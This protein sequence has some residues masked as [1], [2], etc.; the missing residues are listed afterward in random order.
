LVPCSSPVGYVFTGLLDPGLE[1]LSHCPISLLYSKYCDFGML[2]GGSC[3]VQRTR[4][5]RAMANRIQPHL[6]SLLMVAISSGGIVAPGHDRHL[7]SE[8]TMVES[9]LLRP[10]HAVV[11]G[12]GGGSWL[13][14]GSLFRP[15]PLHMGVVC[16]PHLAYLVHHRYSM[17]LAILGLSFST[18]TGGFSSISGGPSSFYFWSS[19]TLPCPHLSDSLLGFLLLFLQLLDLC[20]QC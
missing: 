9:A 7:L 1:H 10:R 4:I 6:W 20:F 17:P 3:T 19:W 14:F 11:C 8:S 5:R 16:L 2:V 13:V 12:E 18:S 15:M